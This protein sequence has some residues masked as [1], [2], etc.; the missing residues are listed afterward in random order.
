M[1]LTRY[2]NQVE[3]TIGSR[4]YRGVLR[5]RQG[6]IGEGYI[7]FED[8]QS[9]VCRLVLDEL[10]SLCGRDIRT[11]PLFSNTEGYW[12][13]GDVNKQLDFID[14]LIESSA[15]YNILTKEELQRIN[16]CNGNR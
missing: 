5:H 8:G 7:H 6:I 12:P 16:Q 1:L 13:Y 9:V 3:I 2:N 11:H 14:E 10:S 4:L 15:L